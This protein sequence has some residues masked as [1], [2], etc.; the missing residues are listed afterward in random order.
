MTR[1]LVDPWLRVTFGATS[2]RSR[3][4]LE[5]VKQALHDKVIEDLGDDRLG[6]VTWRWWPAPHGIRVLRESGAAP[7]VAARRLI[8]Y[9]T[10][11][12][13]GWLVMA[14]APCKTGPGGGA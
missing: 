7:A 3:E 6:P 4:D 5:E 12:P 1:Q 2:T 10:A 9:L 11:H 13:N 8:R 14:S